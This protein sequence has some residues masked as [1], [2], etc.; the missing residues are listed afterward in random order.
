MVAGRLRKRGGKLIGVDI[1]KL[2]AEVSA[3][4]EYPLKA[5]GYRGNLFGTSNPALSAT[6]WVAS[7]APKEAAFH[8][9]NASFAR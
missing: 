3:S 5:S 9:P 1:A 8:P 6:A 7:A 2:S 4:R